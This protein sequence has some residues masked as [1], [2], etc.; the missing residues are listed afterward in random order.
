MYAIRS[1]Y[2]RVYQYGTL[3]SHVLGFV[4]KE[5]K[6]ANGVAKVFEE[7]LNGEIGARMVER[8][9]IGRIITVS[10]EE[11][12]TAVPGDNL[13]LTIDKSYQSILEDELKNGLKQYRG[14]SATGIMMNP[15]TGEVLAMANIADYNPNYYWKFSDF[16][17]KNRAITDL[18]EPGST[19]KVFSRNNFV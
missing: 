6:G 4:D 5:Y 2:A 11:F 13:V 14:E 12:S 8:D 19:F 1:Y 7:D 18:Y 15:N 16:Q 9:A 3:A 17:R 10:D